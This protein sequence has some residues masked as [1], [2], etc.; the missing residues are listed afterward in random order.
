MSVFRF[1][2]KN[3]DEFRARFFF[4]FIF[5]LIDGGVTF[6][7]PVLFTEFTRADLTIGKFYHL[8]FY[9]VALIFATLI[10][11]WFIRKYGET[12]ATQFSHH[13]RK[14]YFHRLEE[15]SLQEL[16]KYHSGYILSLVNKVADGMIGIVAFAFWALAHS[17]T[18]LVL[19]FIF[20]ARE[21]FLLA[22]VNTVILFV[23][24][25]TS[26]Y[27]S[28]AMVVISSDLNIK[29]AT[30]LGHY[31][32]FMANL[33]TVKKLGLLSFVEKKLNYHT[34]QNYHQIQR[35]QDF[36]AKRWLFLHT[37]F[38]CA[39]FI[40]IVFILFG[41]MRGF[42]ESAIL[43]LFVAAYLKIKALVE[44]LSERMRDIFEMK[45][46]LQN[47]EEVLDNGAMTFGE[48]LPN[49]WNEIRFQNIFFQHLGARKTLEVS[50]F[51]I[52]RGEKIGLVGKSGEGKSTFLHLVNNF[53][54]P[55]KG[56]RCVDENLYEN[57]KPEFFEKNM[58]MISQEVELF[59]LSLRENIALG[60][61]IH[62]KKIEKALDELDL[63]T[64]V[65]GLKDGLDTL[66]GEKG[67]RLSAGQKQRVN[68]IRGLLLDREIYLLDEPSSHL[69]TVTEK[70]VFH[71]LKNHLASKTVILVSHRDS[72]LE[73][74]DR[75]Y[76]IKNNIFIEQ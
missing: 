34:D 33:I 50:S 45:A 22:I 72:L 48:K 26:F 6:I 12:M 25:V 57:I 23:F 35:L 13:L 46:Y 21:S 1:I 70:R 36:H 27:L 17:I 52:K 73:L 67:V 28:R 64:W 11:Q 56:E 54:K 20:T 14:K 30:L 43:I 19:F 61:K 38:Y 44:R 29:H 39:F 32:D 24:L 58:V 75:V 68:L 71:F 4:A 53:L 59:N 5:A 31:A 37:L 55:E 69:D 66:V 2:F 8:I 16:H 60:E 76:S 42:Y 40:T 51:S 3:L 74:C 41:I 65:K 62:Y 63:L 18:T 7:I 10:L 47:L 49:T 15:I 9:L